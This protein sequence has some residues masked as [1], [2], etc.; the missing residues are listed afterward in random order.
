MP[1]PWAPGRR[2]TGQRTG[3]RPCQRAARVGLSSRNLIPK[4]AGLSFAEAACL[5]TAWLTAY[6]MLFVRGELRPGQ[7]VLVQGAGG[8][9]A[10]AAIL[11][12]RAAGLHVTVSSRSQEKLARAL[13][14]GAHDAIGLGERLRERVDGVIETVGE[15]T[16]RHSLRSVR[17]GGVIVCAGAT[18]GTAPSAD[19]QHVFFRQLR[20]VGSTMGPRAQLA[21]LGDMLAVTGVR[22]PIDA[23]FPLHG[24][25]AAYA[26]MERGEVFGKLVLSSG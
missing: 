1:P 18:S 15:A 24:A 12:A 13:E 11:L 9:V 20:I 7:R 5:P 23:T 4:P 14:L 17:D 2:R 19:L 26:R 25:R 10:T 6:G 21:D 22:P 16:W 3:R 8:G